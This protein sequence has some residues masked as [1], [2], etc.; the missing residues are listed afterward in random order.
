MNVFHRTAAAVLLISTASVHAPAVSRATGERP[1]GAPVV[2]RVIG[3]VPTKLE[4]SAEAFAKL[5][6]KTVRARGH[7]GVE[8]SYEGVPLVDLLQAAGV[9]FGRELRGPALAGYL[10]VEAADGY[11]A[12]FALPE[13]DPAASD[14]VILLA[15][16]RDGR[17]LDAKAGPLQVIVP[18]E[19]LHYRWVRQVTALRLGR[20]G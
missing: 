10:V 14:R 19:K 4:L 13:L 3:D 1:A 6:R 2:L 12:V 18:G 5:P 20:S 15:D 9:N 11:R 17:A 8:S 16:H 7:D